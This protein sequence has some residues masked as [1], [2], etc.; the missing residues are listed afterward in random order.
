M[1]TAYNYT[2]KKNTNNKSRYLICRITLDM[3][4]VMI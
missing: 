1:H 2:D 4:I 3:W